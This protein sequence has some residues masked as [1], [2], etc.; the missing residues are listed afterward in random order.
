MG[1]RVRERERENS[2]ESTLKKPN[3]N[4]RM[5]DADEFSYC[6]SAAVRSSWWVIIIMI[7]NGSNFVVKTS[8]RPEVLSEFSIFASVHFFSRSL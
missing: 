8:I 6:Y 7:E 3:W 2:S 4:N 1:E 5:V